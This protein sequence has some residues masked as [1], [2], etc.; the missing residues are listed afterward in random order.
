MK[1]FLLFSILI[2]T[3]FITDL[4]AQG[5]W[6][7]NAQVR[8]RYNML[9]ADFNSDTKTINYNEL[10]TRLGIK[11][12]PSD[13]ISGFIQLQDSRIMGSEFNTLKDGSADNLDAHQAYAQIKNLFDLPLH[14]KTG[15]MEAP[16]G[17]ERIMGAV[18]WDNIG[19][20]FDGLMLTHSHGDNTINFFNFKEA[21]STGT[22]QKFGGDYKDK[23][24]TGVWGDFKIND[25]TRIQA[26]GIW[27]RAVG[28]GMLSRITTGTQI[29]MTMGDFSATGEFAYQTGQANANIDIAAMMYALHGTFKVDAT[30]LTAGLA[31]ISGDDASTAD[32]NEAFNTLYATNHKFY[33]MMDYFL[34]LPVHTSAGGLMDIQAKA[35]I[36][37]G[38]KSNISATFHKFL[39]NEK[40]AGATDFGNEIDIIVNHNYNKAAKF[41]LGLGYFMPGE[42][43]KK[44]GIKGFS[45]EDGAIYGYLMTI[46]NLN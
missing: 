46:I 6:S 15:R 42:I 20:S 8:H 18:G 39:A 29:D 22:A 45:G 5:S 19:R 16:F 4:F 35:A 25:D 7:V 37:V 9:G 23:E 33:G 2:G 40:V 32:K 10:R 36:K 31:S 21:D 17:N 43:A 14:I 30:S 27:D 12:A 28:S 11:F 26:Y 1:R 24:I 38:E 3:F 34:N 44:T 13:D 41:Q